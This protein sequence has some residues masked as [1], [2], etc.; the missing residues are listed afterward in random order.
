MNERQRPNSPVL[1]GEDMDVTNSIR[2]I[3]KARGMIAP[4][5]FLLLGALLSPVAGAGPLSPPPGYASQTQLV[6]FGFSEGGMCAAPACAAPACAAPAPT[7]SAPA[8]ATC[9]APCTSCDDGCVGEC[10]S[11]G[12]FSCCL[13]TACCGSYCKESL[14]E[15]MRDRWIEHK[16][17]TCRHIRGATCYPACAPFCKPNYGYYQTCWRR[18]YDDCRCPPNHYGTSTSGE[19]PILFSPSPAEVAP[20]MMKGAPAPI[21]VPAPPAQPG[22]AMR[23]RPTF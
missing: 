22:E 16:K 3:R 5:S 20:P 14:C 2:M 1:K 19:A 23:F 6:G 8:C 21:P 11:C 9:A 4:V 12:L 18:L 7:C 10:K 15:R 17:L 13:G